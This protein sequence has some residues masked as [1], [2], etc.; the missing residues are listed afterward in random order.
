MLDI[1]ESVVDDINLTMYYKDAPSNLELKIL[2]NNYINIE[3]GNAIALKIDEEELFYGYIFT[4]DYEENITFI[5]AYDRIRYLVTKDTYTYQNK[6]A[7]QIISMICDDFCLEKGDIED[8]SYII[9]YRIEENQSIFNIIYNALEI[10]KK[11]NGKEFIFFDNFGKICLKSLQNMT[12]DFI[13]NLD[14]DVFYYKKS[15]SIDNDVYNSIKLSIQDSKT[16]ILS[17]IQKE[18]EEN[19]S[20]WGILKYYEKL[21]STYTKAQ[22]ETYAKN[23]LEL[24][25]KQKFEIYLKMQ[26]YANIRAGNIINILD[27]NVYIQMIITKC[28]HIV[29]NNFHNMELTLSSI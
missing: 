22:A 9:S 10:S 18:D 6:T 25:N 3:E 28:I 8:T 11:M 21:S 12:L 1:S 5:K 27:N 24:K 7:S 14:E 26:G 16:K 2:K 13:I 29:S 20:K 4:I 23:L 19:K 15:Y 17:T